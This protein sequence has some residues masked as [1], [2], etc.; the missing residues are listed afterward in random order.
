MSM[1]QYLINFLVN[2]YYFIMK[3]FLLIWLIVLCINFDNL[4]NLF[5]RI[6]K[7]TWLALSG[8]ILIGFA[9]RMW[10]IPH[11]HHVYSD[12]FEHINIAENM[13]YQGKFFVT[14]KGTSQITQIYRLEFWQPGYHSILASVFSIFGNSEQVAYNLSA[15]IGTV[16]ILIIFLIAYLLFNNRNIA[17]FCAFLFNIIPVHLKYSGASELSITSLFFTLSTLLAS[18]V[19]LRFINTKS[20]LLLISTLVF[21]IYVRPENGILLFLI[22][23]FLIMNLDA[24]K[25]GKRIIHGHIFLFVSLVF[26]FLVPYFT[27][28]YLGLFVMP[29]L[30]WADSLSGRMINLKKH[31]LDNLVF[32]FSSFHP[33]SFTIAAIFSVPFLVKKNKKI[34]IFFSVWFIV[35]LLLYSQ[36]HI[37][38]FLNYA[39]GD[40][41]SLNLYISLVLFAGFGIFEFINLFK[42]KKTILIFVLGYIFI[43]IFS[44]LKFGLN[45]TFSRNVYKEYRFILDNKEVIPDDVYVIAFVP[46]TVISSIHKMAMT[47][48]ILIE[49]DQMPEEVILFKD[50]W[51]YKKREYSDMVEDRLKKV[52]DFEILR[53]KKIPGAEDFYFIRLNK[54]I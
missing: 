12:E 16:S 8:I 1:Q 11:M 49:M 22:P 53:R 47:P 48:F 43:E 19:Y 37:G 52:Y 21:T 13:L 2:N 41:Y 35:F 25:T 6:D 17:L 27:H 23:L 31:L 15:L 42:F 24:K 34:F 26:L 9:L 5:K 28:L 38:S 7:K 14:L 54:K 44:P 3:A 51:W 46:S 32:W 4:T 36:Y 20:L 33:L 10:F 29:P 50:H 18:L 45:R 30:G 39:D 40:R